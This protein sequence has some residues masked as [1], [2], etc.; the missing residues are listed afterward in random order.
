MELQNSKENFAPVRNQDGILRHAMIDFDTKRLFCTNSKVLL[1]KPLFYEEKDI[2]MHGKRLINSQVIALSKSHDVE[3]GFDSM[4][5]PHLGKFP[6]E[7]P[8]KDEDEI[9]LPFPEVEKVC[10]KFNDRKPEITLKFSV[11]Q[12]KNV[13]SALDA[14]E[15]AIHLFQDHLLT[16]SNGKTEYENQV[17]IEPLT[18]TEFSSKA[19]VSQLTGFETE[20]KG[21]ENKIDTSLQMRVDVEAEMENKRKLRS[22]DAQVSEEESIW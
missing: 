16:I 21:F 17:V 5:M 4:T 6:Y 1:V 3:I 18:C 2:R 13:L 19:V 8:D 14:G 22:K 12:L 7:K 15:I 20:F 11:K 9:E 10:D